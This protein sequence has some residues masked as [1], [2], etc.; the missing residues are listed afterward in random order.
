M[1]NRSL[2]ECLSYSLS[3]AKSNT[4][5]I[6]IISES[7]NKLYSLIFIIAWVQKCGH[8]KCASITRVLNMSSSAFTLATQ[9]CLYKITRIGCL[10]HLTSKFIYTKI[11]IFPH[12]KSP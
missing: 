3:I 6:T 7:F 1:S 12:T 11:L 2:M 9:Y 10:P 4:L 5:L 8:W